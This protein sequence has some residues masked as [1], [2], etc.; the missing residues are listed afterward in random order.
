MI[1]IPRYVSLGPDEITCPKFCSL[2]D[3]INLCINSKTDVIEVTLDFKNGL[4]KTYESLKPLAIRLGE[5]EENVRSAFRRAVSNRM[6]VEMEAASLEISPLTPSIALLGHP[7]LTDDTF[8]SMDISAKLRQKGYEVLTPARLAHNEIKERAYPYKDRQFYSI[9][10]DN[11][12]SAYTY[13]MLPCLKGIVYITPFACGIDSLV[14]EFIERRLKVFGKDIPYMKL[15]VDEHT[16]EAGFDTRLEA[17]MDM[18][19]TRENL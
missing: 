9:G 16:G 11:I 3:I 19:G 4:E 12:G 18:L 10:M 14:T 8:L 5:S 15:T 17:F 13:A 1:F 2:P 7:Y 6:K